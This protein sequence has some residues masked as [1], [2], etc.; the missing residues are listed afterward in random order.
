MANLATIAPFGFPD[1]DPSRRI[2]LFRRLGCRTCQFYRN[3]S[4]SLDP[5]QARRVVEDIGMSFDSVHGVFGPQHDPSNPDEAV[6]LAAMETY[7]TEGK[8]ALALGGTMVV[9]HPAPIA[10][11][12]VAVTQTEAVARS[13]SMLKTM[14][15][16]AV[17]GE[18]L[19]VTYLFENLPGQ[20]L[21]GSVP[22]ELAAM[23][24]RLDH[25]RVRMCFDT[26]HAHM[27]A[28]EESVAD[29]LSQCLDV[30][31][32]IHVNDNDGRSDEHLLPGHGTI[33]WDELAPQID[34]LPS[35]TSAMLEIF[36]PTAVIE[37]ELS[38]GLSN[39][40]SRW[41]GYQQLGC[42]M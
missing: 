11:S 15:E 8:L 42:T 16:L 9:V 10:S 22:V 37:D 33:V 27:I 17:V 3:P 12:P 25:P 34:R 20:Y 6:R 35:G 30:V 36:Q 26:G 21:F 1:L 41:V 23:I 14:E 2:K 31:A 40:L 32:Y 4:V 19:G 24:R 5:A 39:R 18:R 38:D 13:D 28:R 7:R 29:I